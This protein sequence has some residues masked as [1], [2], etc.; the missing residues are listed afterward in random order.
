V[1]LNGVSIIVHTTG[2]VLDVLGGVLAVIPDFDIGASGF[3]GSPVAKVKTGGMS[4]S[5]AAELAARAL[6][7]GSTVLDKSASLANVLASYSRR[8]EEWDFQKDLAVKEMEQ[9]DKSIAAAELRIALAEK[10]LANQ[11]LQ[12]ENSKATDAFMRSKYT[13]QELYQWQIGQISGVYFQS[14]RLAYDLA[15]RAERC[16]RFELGLE[17]TSYIN[18]GYWD[19]LKKGLMSGEKL[20]YDLRR[21]ESAYME[22]N[23]REFELTKHVSLALLDPM[24]LVK[25]RETGRCFFRIPEESFDLDFPGHYFRRLKSVSLTLP[26]VTGPYTTVSCTLRLLKNSIR[27]NT[28]GQDAYPHNTDDAGLPAEDTRFIE[29]GIPV[30]VVATSSGQNDSGTFELNFRDERYL[31]FEGAGAISEWS[32]ELFNDLPA[33]NPDPSA[34]DFGKM[35]RQFDFTT[36][37]DAVLHLKYTAR[38]DAGPF[39]N[40]AVSYLRG[41]FTED[42]TTRSVRMFEL[43]QEFPAQWHRFL[44]PT[45]AANGN[46]FDLDLSAGLF[47]V[48]DQGKQLKVNSIALLARCRSATEYNV[49]LTLPDPPPAPGDNELTLVRVNQFGGLHFNQEDMLAWGITIEPVGPAEKWQIRVSRDDGT[50][51]QEDPVTKRMEVEDL[52]LVIA[53]DWDVV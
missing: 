36:I 4:F 16:L 45:N 13:N 20:Q 41:Y 3:G 9:I 42:G 34:P 31:P 11:D 6:Y 35:L 39:K 15:K 37:A 19:S 8:K 28:S 51:L 40:S 50:N 10:E 30:K 26:C 14:Y 2:A 12:I 21:M 22:Q 32:L 24:A 44:Y 43:R 29:N 38:E 53:Y 23:R 52:Y 33:N 18:F 49:E 5:K 17:T 48:I 47:R 27:I 46:V 1:A 7:Q 25:L